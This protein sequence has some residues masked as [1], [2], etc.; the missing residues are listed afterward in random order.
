MS[1][2][3]TEQTR[4]RREHHKGHYDRE[5]V[6]RILDE[7][8]FC[9]LAFVEGDQPIVIPT[10]QW[11]M[12]DMVYWHGSSK[13]RVARKGEARNVCLTT[14]RIDGLVLARSAFEHTVNFE[15]VVVVGQ[16][17]VADDPEEKTALLKGFFDRLFP[18][19]W[20][21]LRRMT[22]GELK[23]TAVLGLPLHAASAKIRR[24]PP[25]EPEEDRSTLV[26][27]GVLPMEV[28]Y[29]RAI[30]DEFNQMPL[31]DYLARWKGE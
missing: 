22:S 6:Y 29:N 27:G 30:A 9:H 15:S 2:L 10:M 31:P 17:I 23:A 16:A 7:N 21:E 3:M 20:E 11:R 28:S 13:S 14:S 24:V 25:N 18:G 26:W 12:G 1:D 19:R 5:T 8:P 4:L